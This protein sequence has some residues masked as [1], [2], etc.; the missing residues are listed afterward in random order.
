M[1]EEAKGLRKQSDQG[2][3]AIRKRHNQEKTKSSKQHNQG[4]HAM[5]TAKNSS[6]VVSNL[7]N[8]AFFLPSRKFGYDI[9]IRSS[10]K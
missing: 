8:W 3:D 7:P 2:K 4:N 5:G 6:S 9:V 1:I 10:I